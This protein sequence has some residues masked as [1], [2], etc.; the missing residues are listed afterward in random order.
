MQLLDFW[1]MNT[2]E[3]EVVGV[4]MQDKGTWRLAECDPH[5][6]ASQGSNMQDSKT[7]VKLRWLAE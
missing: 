6:I 2:E 1:G 3:T 4:S 7:A 5:R